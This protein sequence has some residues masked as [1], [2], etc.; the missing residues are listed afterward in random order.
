MTKAQST[1]SATTLTPVFFEPELILER[2]DAAGID[3]A[4]LSVTIPGVDWLEAEHG[5]MVADAANAEALRKAA[6]K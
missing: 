4:V 5:E 2:M 6:G 1:G 3:H